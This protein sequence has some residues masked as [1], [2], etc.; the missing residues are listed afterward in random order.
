VQPNEN[1]AKKEFQALRSK[2]KSKTVYEV[3]FDSEELIKNSVTS[4]NK[5]LEVRKVIVHISTG[6]QKDSLDDVD[7]KTGQSMKS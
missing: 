1:F 4:I 5:S 7:L 2:I 6:T 3:Y